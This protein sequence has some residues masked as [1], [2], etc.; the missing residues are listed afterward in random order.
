MNEVHTIEYY[1]HMKGDGWSTIHYNMN[2]TNG[3]YVM[4]NKPEE[5]KCCMV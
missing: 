3:Y 2:K 1:S 5:Q 4:L